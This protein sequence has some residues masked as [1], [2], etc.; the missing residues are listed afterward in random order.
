VVGTLEFF[1]DRPTPPS[2]ELL[3][4]L[5][6]AGNQLG[7]VIGRE[8]AQQAL[9]ESEQRLRN[10]FNNSPDAIIVEDLAGRILDVSPQACALHES[11]RAALIG[12]NVW[13]LVPPAAREQLRTDFPRLARGDMACVESEWLTLSGQTVP[14]EIHA[15][16][17]EL[18]GQP[19]L[20]LHVRDIRER[21]QLHQQFLQAQRTEAIGQL[22]G[23]VAHDF[24]NILT[25]ITGY[26]ELLLGRADV[27]DA[28]RRGL[29]EIKK[30][31][32]RGAN[33]TRQLLAFSRKQVLQPQ[34]LDLNG[35]VTDIEKLL[36]RLIGENIRLLT[37]LQP[38]LGHVRADPVQL[39]QVL[40][41]LA[42][43]ARDA[44]PNGGSL[45]ISTADVEL[46]AA[47]ALRLGDLPAGL[48]VML[49]VTDTGCGMS[50]EVL[51]HIFEPFFTTKPVGRGT[52][53]GLATCYGIVKQSGGHIHV[54]SRPGTGTTFRIY[55]PRVDAEL[56]TAVAAP[57]G[58]DRPVGG[59]ETILLAEDEDDVRHLATTTLR[60]LGYQVLEAGNG[61]E[62]LRLVQGR[63]G[64]RLDLLLTDVVMPQISGRELAAVL[65]RRHP[66][67]R[68]LFTSGYT[69]NPDHL[70]EVLRPGVGY[71]E[72]PYT[73]SV[74]ARKVRELLDQGGE[75]PGGNHGNH[76]DRG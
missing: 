71:L 49:R 59:V 47:A 63:R 3:A 32:L 48:Y 66:G 65:Q 16:R 27:P 37:H 13:D 51:A 46:S 30:A 70:P 55:L 1:T 26:S 31:G 4:V 6:Y 23:G 22:A 15:S 29:S 50:P 64:Q 5:E 61:E 36:H 34:V 53:L 7:Q 24:N 45:L 2:A 10:L 28:V 18:A 39:E 25:V 8:R 40:I 54:N 57:A 56:T 62:A 58:A 42:V 60:R 72:K 20:L 69:N 9:R 33:L 75:A 67:L 73:G 41:N 76:S 74:L 35:V 19:A 12:K 11:D 14:V 43:N 38:R 17:I 21:R 52:G 44:M 68:V